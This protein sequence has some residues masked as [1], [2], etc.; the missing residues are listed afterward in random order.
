VTGWL[1]DTNILSA[2]APGKLTI[3]S[4]VAVWFEE[5]TDELFLSA[6]TAADIEAG[7]SQ[8]RRTGPERRANE[9]P[10]VDTLNPFEP[11]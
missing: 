9:P 1:L 10:G 4:N 7:I 11:G 2:F 3:P 6:I 5:R 8:L